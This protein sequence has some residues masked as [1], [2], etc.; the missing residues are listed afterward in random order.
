MPAHRE[1]SRNRTFE[2]NHAP[3][4]RA[5]QLSQNASMI[6]QFQNCRITV[7]RD[8]DSPNRSQPDSMLRSGRSSANTSPLSYN[9]H[10]APQLPN[11]A[12][13]NMYSNPYNGPQHSRNLKPD[14]EKYSGNMIHRH[15][16]QDPDSH[17]MSSPPKAKES[18][19]MVTSKV[20][21]VE[22]QTPTVKKK[23]RVA[24]RYAESAA[25]PNPEFVYV[26]QFKRDFR[27]Y[28]PHKNAAQQQYHVGDVVVTNTHQGDD[29]GIVTDIM[30]PAQL[31]EKRRLADLRATAAGY[32][33]SDDY[34][35]GHILSVA[36]A[37][38]RKQ[39]A[40][41]RQEEQEVMKVSEVPC[42]HCSQF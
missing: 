29:I 17:R 14:S 25:D 10:S 5:N 4:H 2:E 39:Q 21:A 7:P 26:V 42:T 13:S 3:D 32:V 12:S 30:T 6:S 34:Y 38:Q 33:P 11:Y 23:T 36:T 19:S 31:E 15:V 18:T 1:F 9:S 22:S 40:L 27:G 35:I 28:T 20:T 24:R 16:Y 41:L 8:A 37:A